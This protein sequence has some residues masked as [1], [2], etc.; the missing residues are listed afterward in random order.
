MEE[1][2]EEDERSRGTMQGRNYP[3]ENSNMTHNVRS[4]ITAAHVMRFH[5]FASILEKLCAQLVWEES[6]W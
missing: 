2:E 3:A 1:N 4:S 6:R 5:T